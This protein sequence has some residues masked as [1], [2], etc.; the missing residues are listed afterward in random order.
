MLYVA[1]LEDWTY[2]TFEPQLV[3]V[4]AP[5]AKHGLVGFEVSQMDFGFALM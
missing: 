3:I 5:V 1:E 4:P 2:P